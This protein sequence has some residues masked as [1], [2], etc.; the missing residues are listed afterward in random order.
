MMRVEMLV[1]TMNQFNQE[2]LNKMNITTSVTVVNQITQHDEVPPNFTDETKKIISLRDKGL[3]KSRN[4]AL[5]HASKE[6]CV[7]CDDDMQYVNGVEN[8]IESEYI[9]HPDADVIIFQVENLTKQYPSQ[10]KAINWLSSLKVSSV[11]IT[12][13]RKSI[14]QSNISFNEEF[15][16]GSDHYISGEENIFLNDCLTK[17]LKIVYVPVVIGKLMSH[18]SSWFRGYNF[19]YFS[20]KGAFFEKVKPSLSLGFILLF[21]LKKHKYYK[22]ER[23]FAKA[24]KYM[25]DGRKSFKMKNEG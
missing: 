14:I 12:F 21:A 11:Q 1:S 22:Q 6:I 5:K 3:S 19:D 18:D 7:I 15:G 4:L 17:G 16:A 24:I 25:L 23:S 13:R 20:T 8:R 2:F 9:K 10:K